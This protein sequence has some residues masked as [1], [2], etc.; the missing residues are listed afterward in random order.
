MNKKT[1]LIIS[2]SL[3]GLIGL[4]VIIASIM[5]RDE[6]EWAYLTKEVTKAGADLVEL[7]F[8]CPNMKYKETGSDV[9]QNPDLVEK[10]TKIVKENY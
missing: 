9:G 7:N 2:L 10:Y 6:E 4:L 1:R 5:G 8:S 3:N